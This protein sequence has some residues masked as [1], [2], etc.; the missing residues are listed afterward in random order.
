VSVVLQSPR[1]HDYDVRIALRARLA[2]DHCSDDSLILDELGLCEGRAR[3]DVALVN[4]ELTGYEIKSETDTLDRW[5]RQCRRYSQVLD[6][7]W[8]VTTEHKLRRVRVPR[9]WGL[10]RID[11]AK[12]GVA[13]AIVRAANV[14]PKPDPFAIAQLLWHNEALAILERRGQLRGVKSKRR[15][16]AWRRLVDVLTLEELR[17]EVRAALKTRS[18]VRAARR[19]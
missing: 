4:G 14:N 3:V 7:A 2:T 12:N 8:L 5:P 18:R 6:R 16:F 1:M 15:K 10:M 17:H 11:Q 19:P 13:L 9:W